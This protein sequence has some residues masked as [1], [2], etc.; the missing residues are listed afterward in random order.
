MCIYWKATVYTVTADTLSKGILEKKHTKK[1]IF[2]QATLRY[3]S[4]EK[5]I[6]IT[7]AHTL[8]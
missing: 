2:A 6:C 3:I 5:K 1:K 7:T 4:G 8:I